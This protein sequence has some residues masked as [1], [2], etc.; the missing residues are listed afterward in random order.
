MGRE[1]DNIAPAAMS[2]LL[3]YGYPGNVRE[4]ENLIERG[5]ALARG[6]ELR[7]MEL[8]AA[9]AEQAILSVLET[10]G[11]LPSLAQREEDYIRYVLE[12]CDGN[13]T[14]AAQMSGD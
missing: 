12:H 5:V 2:L 1:V 4:L 11:Q 13:R 8:P 7:V 14:R 3:G 6:N 9:L 10:Q